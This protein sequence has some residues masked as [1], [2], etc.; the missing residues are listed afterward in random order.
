MSARTEYHLV[1]AHLCR[2]QTYSD[3]YQKVPGFKILDNGAA[4]GASVSNAFLMRLADELN[5][6]EVVVPDVLSNCDATLASA[7][8]FQHDVNVEAARAA[9]IKFMGVIQGT[10][11]SEFMKCLNGF[12][13]R[14]PWI[15]TIGIPRLS[16][17]HCGTMFRRFMA[18]FIANE[19]GDRF[20]IHCLGANISQPMEPLFLARAAHNWEAIIRGIDTSLPVVMGLAGLDITIDKPIPR[21]E[22]FF[23][24]EPADRS[25]RAWIDHNVDKYLEWATYPQ[26]PSSQV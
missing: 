21:Q 10:N 15:T 23:D 25:R 6:N 8:E 26:A 2:S 1:L 24:L 11:T 16:I 13:Y 14:H 18:E 20:E 22:N 12:A 9:G 19:F 5:V 3:F 17:D 4:E 7:A